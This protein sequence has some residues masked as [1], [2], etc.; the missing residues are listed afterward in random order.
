VVAEFARTASL[1]RNIQQPTA[2]MIADID[3]SRCIYAID[4]AG[5]ED[6]ID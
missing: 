3:H 5:R 2:N 4:V 1:I 6:C